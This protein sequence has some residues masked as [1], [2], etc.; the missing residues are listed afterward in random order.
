M[1]APTRRQK[2]I[3]GTTAV[4]LHVL[5]IALLFFIVQIDE[6]KIINLQLEPDYKE[7]LA[8]AHELPAALKPKKSHLGVPVVFKDI[9]SNAAQQTDAAK[10]SDAAKADA[11]QQPNEQKQEQASISADTEKEEQ[12]QEIKT[13]LASMHK[14]KNNT[15]ADQQKK[16]EQNKEEKKAAEPKPVSQLCKDATQAA[17][18]RQK[19]N[20]PARQQ[21]PQQPMP[22]KNMSLADLTRGFLDQ[23]KDEG[24]NTIKMEGDPNKMPTDEQLKHERYLQ[25]IQWCLQ[26]SFKIY[27]ERAP[28][29]AENTEVKV[30]L[31][32]EQSGHINQVHIAQTSGN[33]T[34]DQFMLFAFNEA[35]SSFPPL[36]Q[37]IKKIP[38]QIVY[39]IVVYNHGW[40]PA[41]FSTY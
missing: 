31:E 33:P 41:G 12:A 7:L 36:P 27:R 6:K 19:N 17:P 15:Q 32:I 16:T 28:M 10:A 38:L 25:K 4:G 24:N 23:I 37:F 3:I 9:P 13:M 40:A 8:Q 1:N 22:K 29:V 39:T 34:F 5:M 20:H 11:A 2:I 21:Q 35:S 30:Y 14:V 18:D 26:N